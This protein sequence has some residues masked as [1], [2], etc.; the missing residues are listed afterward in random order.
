MTITKG[1][2]KP[3]SI[4]ISNPINPIVPKDHVTPINT[5]TIEINTT[6]KDLKKKKSKPEVTSIAS[7]TNNNKSDLT[8][9]IVTDL[10]KGN[11]EKCKSMNTLSINSINLQPLLWG[12][13]GA[14]R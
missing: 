13:A 3:I 8:L 1:G 9:F 6:L 2:I 7:I 4:V 5:T 11:P 12:A 14:H 10:I